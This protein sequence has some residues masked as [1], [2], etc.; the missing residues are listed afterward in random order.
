M[1]DTVPK[2]TVDALTLVSELMAQSAQFNFDTMD[3]LYQSERRRRITTHYL[4]NK[5]LSDIEN[6]GTTAQYERGLVRIANA[7]YPSE[8][9]MNAIMARVDSGEIRL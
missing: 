9:T 4:I 7:L 5:A 8:E 6:G 3:S 1:P 2:E